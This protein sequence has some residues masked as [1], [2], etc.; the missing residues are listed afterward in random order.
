MK[1]HRSKHLMTL[2][3]VITFI[4]SVL[5]FNGLAADADDP[6]GDSITIVS[7]TPQDFTPGSNVTFTAVVEYTLLSADRAEVMLGVNV[8]EENFFPMYDSAEIKKGSGRVTLSAD[9]TIPLEWKTRVYATLAA[10]DHGDSWISLANTIYSFGEEEAAKTEPSEYHIGFGLK[11][12]GNDYT[13]RLIMMYPELQSSYAVN[14]PESAEDSLEYSWGF[15]FTYGVKEYSISTSWWKHGEPDTVT[16]YDMQTSLW[17][18]TEDGSYA[19]VSDIPLSVED[20]TLFW[21]F[22][23]PEDPDASG[24][25]RTMVEIVLQGEKTVM[26]FRNSDGEDTPPAETEL[27]LP[28]ATQYVPYREAIT[29]SRPGSSFS[30]TSGS[31]PKGLSLEPEGVISGFP[32]ELGVFSFAV[33]ETDSDGS[34]EHKCTLPVYSRMYADV[35]A[36]NEPGYGF[37]E[38]AGDD[39][40]VKDQSVSSVSELTDQVMHLEGAFTEFRDLY[41]DARKLKRNVEYKAE[42]GSTKITILAETIGEAGGGTHTLA[43]EFETADSAS[44]TG[45]RRV[46]TVQN[47]VVAGIASREVRVSVQGKSVIWTDAEPYIDTNYRTMT[48]FRVVGEALGLAMD[49][50]GTAREVSFTDGVKT[51]YFP[52]D[53]PE[54]RFGNGEIIRMDTSAVLVNGR[55]YAPIRTLAESFGWTVAWDAGNRTVLIV[56]AGDENQIPETNG[57]ATPSNIVWD[58][59]SSRRSPFLWIGGGVLLLAALLAGGIIM[60]RRQNR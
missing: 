55:S 36:V 19:Y 40:R 54:A 23:M 29:P 25:N 51:I 14:L 10:I 47:Y 15:Y 57:I 46:Y 59:E 3:F 58:E 17:E 4:L 13:A 27:D 30:L 9:V 24:V 38:T 53:S 16:L 39:G 33:T 12:D 7:V 18:K 41:L 8:N 6:A 26:D 2:V 56:K 44:L 48:P 43:A 31:L 34:T 52:I 49:W 32:E 5:P 21:T 37:V 45:S 11:R 42:E 35:E 22:S 50:D 1:N 28:T 60:K 20:S